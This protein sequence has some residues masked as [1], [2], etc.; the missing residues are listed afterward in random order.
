MAIDKP[1]NLIDHKQAWELLPWLVNETLSS[2]EH[3]MVDSHVK[4]CTICQRELEAQRHLSAL[5][6]TA[7]DRAAERPNRFDELMKHIDAI[8]NAETSV[9]RRDESPSWE[10]VWLW[11]RSQMVMPRFSIASAAALAVIVAALSFGWQQGVRP[12]EQA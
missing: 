5:I 8:D 2:A 4:S 6:M 11:I 10:S 12:G 1:I 3:R 7:D 9:H